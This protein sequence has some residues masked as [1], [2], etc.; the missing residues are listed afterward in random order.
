MRSQY[1]HERTSL[2]QNMPPQLASGHLLKIGMSFDWN[3]SSD[4]EKDVGGDLEQWTRQQGFFLQSDFNPDDQDN[5]EE[6]DEGMPSDSSTY[7]HIRTKHSTYNV[8]DDEDDEGEECI[9]WEDD[10]DDIFMKGIGS[11]LRPVSIDL[12]RRNSD[13][14]KGANKR[15][16]LRKI[17]FRFESLSQR[18]RTLLRNVQRAYL[19]ALIS[20]AVICSLNFM[21]EE[22]FA[23][24]L[25]LI[26]QNLVEGPVPPTTRHVNAMLSWYTDWVR[27]APHYRRQQ[28]EANRNAGAPRVARY[29]SRSG[30]P[31]EEIAPRL[32]QEQQPVT[33]SLWCYAQSIAD[34]YSRDPQLAPPVEDRGDQVNQMNEIHFVSLLI[35]MMRS[36]GWRT[37]WVQ[38]METVP[39]NLGVDH[40]LVH[41][42]GGKHSRNDEDAIRTTD[43]ST[44]TVVMDWIEVCCS[45]S[46]REGQDHRKWIHVDPHHRAIDQP[47]RMQEEWKKQTSQTAIPY[48]VAVE[49]IFIHEL[50]LIRRITDVTARYTASWVAS[51]RERGWIRGKMQNF[52]PWW[53]KT[54]QLLNAAPGMGNCAASTNET[55]I[56]IL[57][58]DDEITMNAT[59]SFMNDSDDCTEAKELKAM[60]EQEVIPSS[61]AAFQTHPLYVIPSVLG[62]SE[63]IN[64]SARIRGLFKGERVYHRSDVSTALPAR[65]W[66][67]RGRR[68]KDG[69][70]PVKQIKM[71]ARP[72]PQKSRFVRSKH[73][74]LGLPPMGTTT[75]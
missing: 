5:Q 2:S 73:M 70:K 11:K 71:R 21:D 42:L 69:M 68:V 29:R 54:L 23:L 72:N 56:T 16:R 55:A 33:S 12:N 63:V 24:A 17:T 6:N 31:A 44:S 25:S 64:P 22:T 45:V 9:D 36:M 43:Q 19:L 28:I 8:Q 18:H 35:L 13:E 50:V 30:H 58:S 75:I 66:L 60:A 20:R 38:A 59:K 14:D 39:L 48:V 51:L 10:T 37:R 27:N 32:Q 41:I 53:S 74:A 65:K 15:K 49:H 40:P 67:Y 47:Q 61:K 7:I 52:D 4:D 26:P 62:K 1:I 3:L 57:D 34:C 46:T